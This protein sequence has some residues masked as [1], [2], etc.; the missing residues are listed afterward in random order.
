VVWVGASVKFPDAC[1]LFTTVW[2]APPTVAVITTDDALVLCHVSV[3]LCP[4]LIEVLLAENVSVGEPE[5]GFPIPCDPQP[6]SVI[7]RTT[8]AK[9]KP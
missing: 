5:P 3:T 9:A 8:A 7:R 2:D 6:V 4:L 1:G